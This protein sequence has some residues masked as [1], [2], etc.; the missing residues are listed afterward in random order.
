MSNSRAAFKAERDTRHQ[1]KHSSSNRVL[2][3]VTFVLTPFLILAICVCIVIIAMTNKYNKAKPYAD[4]MFDPTN[5]EQREAESVRT[6][7]KYRDDD[8][9]L[10][11]KKYKDET[12]GEEHAIIY[13]YYGD[14]YGTV[15]CSAAGMNDLP[16]YSGDSEDVLKQGVGWFN[17][18]V[19]IGHVGNVVLAAHNHTFFLNLP[20]CKIGDEVVIDTDYVKQTY[21]VSQI[22]VFKYTDYQWVRPTAD[23]RLT[24]YTCWNQ[25]RLGMSDYRLAVICKLTKREWKKVEVSE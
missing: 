8:A 18:S 10:Q 21:I 6:L 14:F 25:G 7:N 13:P 22:E 4:M 23:D 16:I 2:R 17:G 11:I 19:F 24:M 5:S 15:S 20:N 9:P 3:V 1:H 12:T